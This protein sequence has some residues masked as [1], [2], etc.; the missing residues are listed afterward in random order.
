V[1]TFVSLQETG[2]KEQ[3]IKQ[4][5]KLTTIEVSTTAVALVAGVRAKATPPLT[6]KCWRPR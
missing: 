5:T 1:V 3:R 6:A 2:Q 4:V